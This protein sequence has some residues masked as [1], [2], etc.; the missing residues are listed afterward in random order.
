MVAKSRVA[1]SAPAP[2]ETSGDGKGRYVVKESG[3]E[4]QFE[5]KATHPPTTPTKYLERFRYVGF[6]CLC[7]CIAFLLIL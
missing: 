4:Y 7:S 1:Q 3:L 2:T 6:P 5:T